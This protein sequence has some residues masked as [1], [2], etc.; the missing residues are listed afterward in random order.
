[1]AG[2]VELPARASAFAAENPL[3]FGAGRAAEAA[4]RDAAA[5]AAAP[6]ART[7]A[8]SHRLSTHA[9]SKSTQKVRTGCSFTPFI[10]YKWVCLVP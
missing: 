3:A 4:K 10:E 9:K 7:H 2:S 5:P 1:M 6:R 8:A